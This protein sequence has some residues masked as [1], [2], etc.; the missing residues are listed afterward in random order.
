MLGTLARR[1]KVPAHF[2]EKKKKKKKKT[3]TTPCH[4]LNTEFESLINERANK[5]DRRSRRL[6]A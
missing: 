4:K 6:Q 1:V 3:T 2:R 5:G